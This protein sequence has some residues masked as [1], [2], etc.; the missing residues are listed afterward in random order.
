MPSYRLICKAILRNDTALTTL[1]F[2]KEKC[3]AYMEL[4]RI[5]IEAREK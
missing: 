1:G 3:P 5:E 4:K 2:A